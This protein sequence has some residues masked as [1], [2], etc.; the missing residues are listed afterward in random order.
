M[1]AVVL[2]MRKKRRHGSIEPSPCI[3]IIQVVLTRVH[4]KFRQHMIGPH[5]SRAVSQ[6]IQYVVRHPGD[7]RFFRSLMS[8]KLGFTNKSIVKGWSQV[9]YPYVHTSA[10]TYC[11][12]NSRRLMSFWPHSRSAVSA[13]RNSSAVKHYN[14]YLWTYQKEWHKRVTVEKTACVA[15]IKFPLLYL[16]NTSDYGCVLP[17]LVAKMNSS[18]TTSL[19]PERHMLFASQVQHLFHLVH[20]YI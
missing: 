18:F 20:A 14:R 17:K 6:W 16:S 4:A 12:N 15:L 10:R 9:T 8:S 1:V 19:D 13:W 2:Y 3:E 11:C 5:L 7:K